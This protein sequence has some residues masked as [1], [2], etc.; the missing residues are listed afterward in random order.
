[1]QINL[2]FDTITLCQLVFYNRPRTPVSMSINSFNSKR[3]IAH[4][5]AF[6]AEYR[7][8]HRA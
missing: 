4:S 5:L 8:G 1:M 6:D 7:T 2:M 3:K